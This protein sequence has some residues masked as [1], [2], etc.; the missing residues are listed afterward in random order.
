MGGKIGV[1]AWEQSALIRNELAQE[2][3]VPEVERVNG[4]VDFRLRTRGARLVSTAVV[5]SL[6]FTLL[7]WHDLS[8]GSLLDLSM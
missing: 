6:V 3:N 7:A 1:L 8:L 4:E 2:A 5:T